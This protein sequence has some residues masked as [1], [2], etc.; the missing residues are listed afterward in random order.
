MREGEKRK[1]RAVN[2]RGHRALYHL[3][4][5]FRALEKSGGTTISQPDSL[6]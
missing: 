3:T 4:G 2:H 6:S 5:N 1:R